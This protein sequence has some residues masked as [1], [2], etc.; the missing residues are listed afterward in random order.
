MVGA[1][2]G[3]NHS[4]YSEQEAM[5]QQKD[6][7]QRSWDSRHAGVEMV[8]LVAVAVAE[9]DLD[10]GTDPY[11]DHVEV[12]DGQEDHY[13]YQNLD[14]ASF[15]L[16]GDSEHEVEEGWVLDETAPCCRTDSQAE[17]AD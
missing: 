8:V 7:V 11:G 3:L 13:D 12:Y 14:T 4:L 2:Q 16:V 15:G 17:V 5:L 9:G 6:Q 1:T 10:L